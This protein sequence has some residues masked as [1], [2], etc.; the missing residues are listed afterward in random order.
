M[1]FTSDSLGLS[2][3]A[4][5]P[6]DREGGHLD[7]TRREE[8]IRRGSTSTARILSRKGDPNRFSNDREQKEHT[9]RERH[10][11]EQRDENVLLRCRGDSATES[12]IVN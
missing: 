7:R 1:T 5:A 3:V 6:R 10:R 4:W 9:P 11:R 2:R 8:G 12:Y